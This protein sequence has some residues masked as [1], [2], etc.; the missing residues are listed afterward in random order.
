MA[1]IDV[2]TRLTDEGKEYVKET[3][4]AQYAALQGEI[5]QRLGSQSTVLGWLIGLTGA[6]IG[7]LTTVEIPGLTQPLAVAAVSG[8]DRNALIAVAVLAAAFTLGVEL[9]ISYWIY[10]LFQMFRISRYISKMET[11]L[12]EYLDM[13][14]EMVLFGWSDESRGLEDAKLSPKERLSTP[15]KVALALS[16]VSQPASLYLMGALGLGVLLTTIIAMFMVASPPPVAVR[17]GL[18][19]LCGVLSAGMG[20]FVFMHFALHKWIIGHTCSPF[21]GVSS[22]RNPK[23]EDG[24][25]QQ[26]ITPKSEPVAQPPQG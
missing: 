16:S 1:R 3:T 13:P 17:V 25:F 6:M 2:A 7:V 4:L 26:P 14:P 10:Q 5:V 18:S 23:K 24:T 11:R 21:G 12:R 19:L 20:T 9:L 8:T 22:D 15:V